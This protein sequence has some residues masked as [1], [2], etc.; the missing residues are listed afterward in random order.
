VTPEQLDQLRHAAGAASAMLKLLAN[1]DRL[2]LLCELANGERSVSSLEAATGIRQPTLSQ[3]L[4]VLRAEGVVSTHRAGKYILYRLASREAEQIMQV[5]YK[6]YCRP[7]GV[8]QSGIEG[9]STD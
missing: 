1:P 7:D 8:D 4:G 5:L 9:R 6:L 3:Q 2:L